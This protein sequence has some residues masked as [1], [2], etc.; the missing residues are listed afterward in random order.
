LSI[1]GDR[2]VR[3]QVQSGFRLAGFAVLSF[4]VCSLLLLGA[5]LLLDKPNRFAGHGLFG[6]VIGGG[7]LAVLSA[8]LFFTTRFW[9]KWF[10]AII[11]F[12]FLRM[13]VLGVLGVT[14]VRGSR[15]VSRS[16]VFEVALILAVL[17]GLALKPSLSDE[18]PTRAES[19]GLVCAVLSVVLS[20]VNES[21]VPLLAG[22]TALGIVLIIQWTK[23]NRNKQRSGVNQANQGFGPIR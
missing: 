11:L 3:E 14:S 22:T 9:A 12:A 5:L 16:W 21:L 8:L 20:V 23:Q 17:A 18:G 1:F 13:A 6:R 4:A 2:P 10:T 19:A 7:M 15:P